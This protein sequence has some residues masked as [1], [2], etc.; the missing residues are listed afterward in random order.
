MRTIH[1]SD[2]LGIDLAGPSS[3][4]SHP[5]SATPTAKDADIMQVRIN[6]ESRHLE[7]SLALP[8]L[9]D[10]LD[11]GGKRVA[12]EHNGVIVPRSRYAETQ[13]HDGDELLIVQ[14]IGGG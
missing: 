5:A 2:P 9:L 12:I 6:G 4:H 8:E 7:H 11:L 10:V 1:A 3:D 13:V 14:A